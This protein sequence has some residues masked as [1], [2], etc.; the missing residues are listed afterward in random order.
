[1][2]IDKLVFKIVPKADWLAACTTGRFAGSPDDVRDGFIQLSSPSQIAGTL[3]KHFAD[4][5]DLLLV[6]FDGDRLGA[7]L[8]FEISRGGK[9]FPHYYA[10][11]PTDLALWTAP[12]RLRS[13]GSVECD[14]E[15]FSC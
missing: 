14:H 4:V 10:A 11:L 15:I 9:L 2:P 1:M 8:R 12:I 7:P 13:D 5:P 3:A 6:A